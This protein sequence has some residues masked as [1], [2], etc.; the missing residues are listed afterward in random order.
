MWKPWIA[1][2][3]AGIISGSGGSIALAEEE[4][5]RAAQAALVEEPPIIDGDVN[6][7]VWSRTEPLTGFI[8]AEPVE[9][10]PALTSSSITQLARLPMSVPPYSFG[11]VTRNNPSFAASA[12]A[13]R[14]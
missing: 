9:G 6:E 8:Q 3:A 11:T 10:Q 12:T 2:T 13:D 7:E 1:L 4:T 14:A 5:T